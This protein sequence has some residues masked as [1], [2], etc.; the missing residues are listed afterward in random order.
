MNFF[1]SI[2][3]APVDPILG[4]SSAFASD[5]RACKVNLGA[6][7]Y[8]TAELKPLILEAVKKAEALLLESESSKDYLPIDGMPEYVAAVKE[9]VFGKSAEK[10]RIYG[11]QMV[12]GSGALRVGASFLKKSGFS[13][14]FISD[15]SWDNHQRIFTHAGLIVE[16]YPYYDPNH[17]KFDYENFLRKIGEMPKGSIAVLHACCHNPTGFD[18]TKEQWKEIIG[19]LKKREV[20]PFFDFA[21]QGFGEG[22]EEDT[23]SIRL[24]LESGVEFA[25]A[26]SQ[27]KNFGLY[28]ERCGALFFICNDAESAKRVGSQVKIVIRGLYSSPPCHGARIVHTILSNPLLK[29]AWLKELK[30]M[31]NRISEMRITLAK[32]LQQKSGTHNFDFLTQQTG[33]FSYTGLN[34]VQVERLIEDYGIYMPKDGRINIAGL[35]KDNVEYVARAISGKNES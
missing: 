4:I 20:F 5:K 18:P 21:Y 33:M 14:I 9:L 19:Q 35:N 31:R 2:E 25:V 1:E 12:G 32:E 27:S 28:G 26:L 15:P 16:S 13:Q 10:E 3:Q 23:M 30:V 29:E 6:G 7:V 8:K 17:R 24:C 22:V 11:A 34:A